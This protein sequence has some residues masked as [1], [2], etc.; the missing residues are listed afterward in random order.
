MLFFSNY[1]RKVLAEL[2]PEPKAAGSKPKTTPGRNQDDSDAAEASDAWQDLSL[3]PRQ[4]GKRGLC[5]LLSGDV[6]N[7]V[8]SGGS[9]GISSTWSTEEYDE[10]IALIQTSIT[11]I[12]RFASLNR[13]T[14]SRLEKQSQ[15]NADKLTAVE[16][17]FKKVRQDSA[18]LTGPRCAT[19]SGS[20]LG[21]E[22]AHLIGNMALFSPSCLQM[23]HVLKNCIYI[24]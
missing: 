15:V 20:Q 12:H 13:R 16:E 11:N 5:F 1:A 9:S 21:L 24:D 14:L 17:L 2:P 10:R 3:S 23:R 19:S 8:N 4:V 6:S 18:K 7:S 22:N